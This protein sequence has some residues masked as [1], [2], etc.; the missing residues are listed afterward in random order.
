M[1]TRVKATGTDERGT[2]L[3]GDSSTSYFV[4]VLS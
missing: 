4:G 2:N 3:M 1:V